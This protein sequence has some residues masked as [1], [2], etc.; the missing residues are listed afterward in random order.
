MPK[1]GYCDTCN[2]TG[3]IDCLCGGDLCV[4]GAIT[5]PCPDCDSAWEDPDAVDGD[6]TFVE[7]D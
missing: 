5:E 3:E 7:F 6:D 2:N 4:C 1:P